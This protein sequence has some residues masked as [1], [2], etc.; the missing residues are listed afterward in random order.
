MK[1]EATVF[2][3]DDD[4]AMRRSLCWLIQ[5]VPLPV[6]SF[7]S[8][9]DFLGAYRP[10]QPGCLVLDVRLGGMSGLDLQ[11]R[12]ARDPVALPIIFITGYGTV[13][14]A[15]RAMKTGAVDFLAKPFSDQV[16]LDR[17]QAAL[18]L[19]AKNRQE[20]ARRSALALR[21]SHLTP[22]ERQVLELV[23]T[24]KPNKAIAGQLGVSCKTVEVHRAKIMN[25]TQ[26]DSVID[27]VRIADA[28]KSMHP[29]AATS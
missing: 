29:A 26:A 1:P 12:L 24:G 14:L 15:V 19:D 28:E 3:V 17:I 20:H 10:S 21:L 7:A 27:L 9:Q 25:K 6:E 23:I 13:P 18:A 2:I 5:S 16:L 11:E 22:R 8:A 4:E